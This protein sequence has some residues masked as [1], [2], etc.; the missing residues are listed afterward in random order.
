LEVSYW[1]RLAQIFLNR[2]LSLP[3]LGKALIIV[4]AV[5]I[6]QDNPQAI[7]VGFNVLDNS[8]LYD[9]LI[10][11]LLK[12]QPTDKPIA[13]SDIARLLNVS[14]R[15]VGS[16]VNRLIQRGAISKEDHGRIGA[17]YTVH[18][19]DGKPLPLWVTEITAALIDLNN[20]PDLKARTEM[21][22]AE[23]NFKHGMNILR[24]ELREKFYHPKSDGTNR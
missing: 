23:I 19:A 16:S 4:S 24:Q 5:G 6:L 1:H 14:Q 15:V 21:E 2:D 9:A 7:H 8:E 13:Y 3:E 20:D 10:L 17:F 11:G 22:I 18:K 12:R